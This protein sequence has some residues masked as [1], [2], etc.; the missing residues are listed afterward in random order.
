M[1]AVYKMKGQASKE[2]HPAY[3]MILAFSLPEL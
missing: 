1:T 3:T 2:T